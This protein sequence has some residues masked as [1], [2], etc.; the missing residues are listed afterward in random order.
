MAKDLTLCPCSRPTSS[1]PVERISAAA[2]SADTLQ[3]QPLRYDDFFALRDEAAWD[4]F[5]EA[6]WNSI[7]KQAGR[8]YT[9]LPFFDSDD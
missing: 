2:V 7:D 4:A 8:Y 9:P 6:A 1:P 5:E 3:P